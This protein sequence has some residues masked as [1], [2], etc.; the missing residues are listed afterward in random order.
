MH[1]RFVAGPGQLRNVEVMLS[2]PR[3]AGLRERFA[4]LPVEHYPTT[5]ELAA[6][7]TEP[8]LDS[9]FEFALTCLLDG[10]AARQ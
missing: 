7:L 8:D 2:V 9:R 1:G 3:G 4:A 10:I 6:E 5:V